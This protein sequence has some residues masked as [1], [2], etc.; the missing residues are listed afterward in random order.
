MKLA[1]VRILLTLL[2]SSLGGCY[3][4]Q[5]SIFSS[6]SSPGKEILINNEQYD[7]PHVILGPVEYT[8]RKNTSLFVDQI[9]LRNQAID[10][11]KQ[12]AFARFGQK[13][14]AIEDVKVKESNAADSLNQTQ[15]VTQVKGIAIAFLPETK[16]YVKS[17]SRTKSVKNPARKSKP[18]NGVANK[19]NAED[20]TITPSE[21]LK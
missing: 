10:L 3:P 19:E 2:M 8:L 20:I 4:N 14:D 7:K 15:S 6:P 9:E 1:I 16:P 11:L 5:T 21:I 18:S 13:V 17:K 12:S